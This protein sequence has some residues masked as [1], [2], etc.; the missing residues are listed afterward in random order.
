MLIIFSKPRKN[1]GDL[2]LIRPCFESRR[3]LSQ[4]SL[5]PNVL[6]VDGEL[7]KATSVYR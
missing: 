5:F 6:A 4:T 3:V 1:Q 2:V 7:E